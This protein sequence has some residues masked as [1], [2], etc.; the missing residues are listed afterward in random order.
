MVG[1]TLGFP[2]LCLLGVPK[3]AGPWYTLTVL[4]D[5]SLDWAHGS[6]ALRF[7]SV[8]I[9]SLSPLT[10]SSHICG[11]QSASSPSL[12]V[13]E[14]ACCPPTLLT[15]WAPISRLLSPE[16]GWLLAAAKTLDKLLNFSAI[17]IPTWKMVKIL[18]LTL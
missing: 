6:F 16:P 1:R 4:E 14:L 17:L 11:P 2:H 15:I 5:I 10:L 18:L 12:P 7:C 13:V 9:L 8:V 3:R